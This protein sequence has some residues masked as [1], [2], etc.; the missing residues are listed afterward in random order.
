[1]DIQRNFGKYG[2][3]LFPQDV[4]IPSQ[5]SK[6]MYSQQIQLL[7]IIAQEGTFDEYKIN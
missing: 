3:D 6:N 4:E 5:L 7:K 2:V 1:V